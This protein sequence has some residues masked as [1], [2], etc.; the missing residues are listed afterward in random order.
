MK[1]AVKYI[2]VPV[3][4]YN[5]DRKRARYALPG[6]KDAATTEYNDLLQNLGNIG[7]DDEVGAKDSAH[8]YRLRKMLQQM[9]DL[10]KPSAKS[11]R[12][13]NALLSALARKKPDDVDDG[14]KDGS[15]GGDDEENDAEVKDETEE[16]EEEEKEEE[17]EILAPVKSW[18]A[19]PSLIPVWTERKKTSVD[20]RSTPP[21]PP[22]PSTPTVSRKR[23][24]TKY[25]S[26]FP[27]P[28]SPQTDGVLR[29][30]QRVKKKPGWQRIQA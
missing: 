1:H 19:K 11:S 5:N 16:E 26:V 9:K 6:V 12:L 7:K 4:E 14:K 3:A 8:A 18:S 17:D 15:D 20:R 13:E 27:S 29:R 22:P 25:V 24:A 30:G 2:L 28:V 10:S 23:K 21:P